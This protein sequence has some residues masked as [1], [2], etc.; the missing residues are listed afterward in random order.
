MEILID[1]VGKLKIGLMVR[2]GSFNGDK[3]SIQ[4]EKLDVL[5]PDAGFVFLQKELLNTEGKFI[6]SRGDWMAP[7]ADFSGTAAICE[8]LIL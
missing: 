2:S 5:P 4:L 8:S 7:C 1:K 6:D 3:R